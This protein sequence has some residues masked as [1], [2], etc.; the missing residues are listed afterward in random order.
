MLSD[1]P[2][3]KL[4]REVTCVLLSSIDYDFAYLRI[5]EFTARKFYRLRQCDRLFGIDRAWSRD[6]S[7]DV[8]RFLHK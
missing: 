2:K 8:N 3:V 1:R 4:D 5:P 6:A 7:R